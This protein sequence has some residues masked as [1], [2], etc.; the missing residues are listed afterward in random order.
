MTSISHTDVSVSLASYKH[1]RRSCPSRHVD[2]SRK[3]IPMI[4]IASILKYVRIY[5]RSDI[6]TA[7]DSNGAPIQ[8][9][10]RVSCLI[11]FENNSTTRL[12]TRNK[13]L[14]ILVDIIRNA[15]NYFSRIARFQSPNAIYV[16]DGQ[17]PQ[18]QRLDLER[19]YY[20]HFIR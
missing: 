10:N 19:R 5:C 2:R 6:E 8:Q 18:L 20:S 1:V 14:S 17:K 7:R 9:A 11:V 4:S 15:K 12:L 3:L 13:R 16:D